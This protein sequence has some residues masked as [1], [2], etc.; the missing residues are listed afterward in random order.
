MKCTAKQERN[1]YQ[2]SGCDDFHGKRFDANVLSCVQIF[3]RVRRRKIWTLRYA[4]KFQFTVYFLIHSFNNL[5]DLICTHMISFSCE[6]TT[7]HNIHMWH[8]INLS[9]QHC[10]Q[11]KLNKNTPNW[12]LLCIALAVTISTDMANVLLINS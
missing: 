3:D 10:I 5:F 11:S 6:L 9:L 4:S 7:T 8:G 12:L 1:F 2:K